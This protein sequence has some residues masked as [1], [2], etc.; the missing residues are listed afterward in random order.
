M[1]SWQFLGEKDDDSGATFELSFNEPNPH[2]R[3]TLESSTSGMS[4][5]GPSFMNQTVSTI[6]PLQ[7]KVNL[8]NQEDEEEKSKCVNP[9]KP[10]I[11]M[12]P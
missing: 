5:M 10:R 8:L 11:D 12:A 1:N 3:N 4:R 2:S 9:F 7:Y 6:S